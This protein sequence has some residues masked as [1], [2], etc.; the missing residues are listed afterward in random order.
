[1]DQQP[2]SRSHSEHQGDLLAT[3]EHLPHVWHGGSHSP[4]PRPCPLP[5]LV[6]G[7]LLIHLPA[8]LS[9]GR[10]SAVLHLLALCCPP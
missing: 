4:I 1:M 8:E 6:Q 10:G 9:P 2:A 7:K 3:M 5:F